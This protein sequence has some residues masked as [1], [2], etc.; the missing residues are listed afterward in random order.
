MIKAILFTAVLLGIVLPA[1]SQTDTEKALTE[2]ADAFMA[3]HQ[4]QWDNLQQ[5]MDSIPDTASPSRIQLY[6]KHPFYIAYS[7]YL[8]ENGNDYAA[9]RSE[10]VKQYAV[11]PT[12][13]QKLTWEKSALPQEESKDD[14]HLMSIVFLRA[15][16]LFSPAQLTVNMV[17]PYI[18]SEN[19]LT[20]EEVQRIYRQRELYGSLVYAAPA[21]DSD[22]IVYVADHAFA[23]RFRFN[24][25]NG[26]ISEI[27]HTR[28]NDPAYHAL[29]WPESIT[30]PTTE[31]QQLTARITQ[32]LWNSYAAD[33]DAKASY[34]ELQYKRRE[35]VQQFNTQN[36][37]LIVQVREQQ[38]QTLDKGKPSLQGFKQVITEKDNLLNNA[39]TA[40]YNNIAYH[41]K[42][43]ASVL[44]NAAN[45]YM[46]MDTKKIINRLQANAMYSS[47]A[48]ATK[49]SAN[50]WEVYVVNNADAVRYTWNIQTG[51]VHNIGFWLKEAGL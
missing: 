6:K 17:M 40:Y 30:Q 22:R 37:Q 7:Q 27:A 4:S 25:R 3:A 35:L 21:S 49:L 47:A 24:L 1:C 44:S 50:E 29:Q 11:P 10:E 28:Y 18:T 42:Q 33:T 45:L 16:D 8:A 34:T 2:K 5:A 20:I 19:N 36:K 48:Y 46:E 12:A 23:V 15:F 38:L 32:M 43:W 14:M 39:D 41:P 13:L 9:I 51:H 26:M 31:K